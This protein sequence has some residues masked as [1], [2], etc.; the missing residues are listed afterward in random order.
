MKY[1]TD[2]NH[3]NDELTAEQFLQ[4]HSLSIENASQKL[5]KY[6]ECIY[7]NAD[8]FSKTR[9]CVALQQE[10]KMFL[11]NQEFISENIICFASKN[12]CIKLDSKKKLNFHDYLNDFSSSQK[13]SSS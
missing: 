2:N 4:Q 11:S 5:L 8:E 9:K 13:F 10:K 1:I 3:D 12:I 7:N 6:I